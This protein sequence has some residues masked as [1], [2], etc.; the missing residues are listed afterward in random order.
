VDVASARFVP[1]GTDPIKSRCRGQSTKTQYGQGHPS[2]T[3]DER[4]MR[5]VYQVLAGMAKVR[6]PS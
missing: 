1:S 5:S 3:R 4:G 2:L 6:I